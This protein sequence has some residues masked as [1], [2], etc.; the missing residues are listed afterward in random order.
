M[1]ARFRSSAD[2]VGLRWR[3]L[4]KR[5]IGNNACFSGAAFRLKFLD[6]ARRG[7]QGL[8]IGGAGRAMDRSWI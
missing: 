6:C 3:E 5:D 2:I 7:R 4:R 1:V 8:H